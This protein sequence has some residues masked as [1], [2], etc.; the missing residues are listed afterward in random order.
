MTPLTLYLIKSACYIA[1]LYMIYDFFLSKDTQYSR[2]RAFI[3]SALSAS[4]ILPLVV[5]RTAKPID[6]QYI[7]IWLNE[8]FITP[9]KQPAQVLNQGLL[10]NSRNFF[11]TVYLSGVI[12]LTGRLLKTLIDLLLIINKDSNSSD[13][14]IRFR[15]L[16][17]SAFSAFGRIFVPGDLSENDSRQIIIHEQN[18]LRHLHFYDILFMEIIVILQWFNPFIHL[19]NRS[20]RAV[21]EYQADK[22]CI[23]SGIPVANYQKLI[24]NHLFKS[25]V[26]EIPN[27]FSN[28]TLIKRRMIMMTK[29]R[30]TVLANLK[31][32]M[33]LP[34]IAI[35]LIAFSSCN[36][37]A[38]NDPANAVTETKVLKGEE[39]PYDAPP[40]PPPSEDNK[41][42]KGQAVP[43]D[44]PPPPPP[45][46]P[47]I[48]I[49]GD[50]TW[51]VVDK[52]PE[53]PGGNAALMKYI[54]DNV[55]YPES[56]KQ[57]GVQGRVLINFVVTETG[58]VTNI[59][60]GS[61]SPNAELN[62]EA[63]RVAKT[64]PDFESPGIV[65]GRAVPVSFT[66]PITFAL[67]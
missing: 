8:I 52:M 31:L 57:N 66:L 44:A 49:N 50:T 60:Y 43:S 32:L 42:I 19:F 17:A 58:K 9:S 63:L 35:I 28:S 24:I 30:S 62:E 4:L 13:R 47:F 61:R 22:G 48:V 65:N 55:K 53:F 36:D 3:L 5:L 40:P 10:F 21:H 18:H 6:I 45:P 12:I 59:S 38:K 34:V 25:K 41:V 54:Y 7:N 37:K 26:F 67:R 1:A 39:I 64:I 29:K 16:H 15:G 27:S 11:L 2:N 14:V 46:P 23:S 56:A 20:L 51:N 33:V